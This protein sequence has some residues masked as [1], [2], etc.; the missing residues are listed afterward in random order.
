MRHV[1]PLRVLLSVPEPRRTTNPY[2]VMLASAL[3][4]TEGIQVKHFA[5]D[6]ALRGDYDVFH[7]H[8]PDALAMG[9]DVLRTGVRHARMGALMARL[10]ARGVPIVRTLHNPAPHEHVRPPTAALLRWVD[11][12]TR[13]TISLN[14]A[15]AGLKGVPNIVIPHGHYIDWFASCPVAEPVP[16]RLVT[17]GAIRAYKGLEGLIGAVRDTDD[18]SLGLDVMGA[19]SDPGL[20]AALADLAAGDTRIDLQLGFAPDNDLVAKVTSAELVV[21]P[22]RHLHNSGALLAALSMARPVLVPSNP[23]TD[24]LAAEVG[25]SWVQRYSGAL[26][27]A[28]LAAALESVRSGLDVDARPDLS[29]RDWDA[30]G[31]RHLDVYR[32]AVDASRADGSG[33]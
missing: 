9:S 13:A 20:A 30:T 29:A 6:V 21:L 1:G 5:W 11:R 23:V 33:C 25:S 26:S 24:A 14:F 10:Q 18:S 15:T 19:T 17:F 12:N 3:R 4:S 16:G 2:V 7:V 22:Y 8:W 31:A 27:P 32:L 28:V